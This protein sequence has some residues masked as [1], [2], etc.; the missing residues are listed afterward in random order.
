M[1]C[2]ANTRGQRPDVRASG[3]MSGGSSGCRMSGLGGRMSG[4][5][6]AKVL[7]LGVGFLGGGGGGPGC[8]GR[9]S[10]LPAG[11]PV[12]VASRLWGCCCCSQGPDVRA[13]G[14]MSG[15]CRPSVTFFAGPLHP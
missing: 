7:D 13:R 6:L 1:A 2:G 14:R 5:T 12:P 15:S 11:C 9:I 4:R 8:L 3:R 10:G